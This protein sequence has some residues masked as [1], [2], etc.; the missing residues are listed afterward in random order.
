M[1]YHPCLCATAPKGSVS[2]NEGDHLGLNMS[3]PATCFPTAVTTASS[4]DEKLLGEIGAAI[5]EEAADQSGVFLG[6]G[7]NIKRNPLCGRNLS[8]RGSL[9][10]W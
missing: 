7:L 8:I 2:R 1:A 9:S 3:E 4:W 6:P 10:C 5:A